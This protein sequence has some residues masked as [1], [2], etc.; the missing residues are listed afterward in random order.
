LPPADLPAILDGIEPLRDDEDKP[1]ERRNEWDVGSFFDKVLLRVWTGGHAFEV[2]RALQWL[3]TRSSFSHSYSGSRGA[4]LH[5][6]VKATP[7]RVRALAAHFVE[8]LVLDSDRWL[9]FNRFRDLVFHEASTDMLLEVALEAMGRTPE[10]VERELFLYELAFALSYNASRAFGA[11]AF[12][13]LYAMAD[14]QPGFAAI[15][16]KSVATVLPHKH[17][18]WKIKRAE[19][20]GGQSPE[21][22][23]ANFA[24]EI[25]RIRSG[26]HTGWLNW[27]SH[28]YFGLFEDCD[29]ALEPRER[30]I[31]L[32]GTE[33]ADAALAGFEAMLSRTDVPTF[34]EAVT[35]IAERNV[36]AWWH[37]LVAG[38]NERWAR[39]AN[40]DGLPEDLLRALI[41]FDLA[42]PIPIER[43]SSTEWMV[44]PWKE[45]AL[46]T[47]ADLVRDAY[48]AVARA[49]FLRSE[50][51]AEGLRELLTEPQF[52]PWRKDTVISL[53]R[54]FPNA[55][56]FRLGDLLVGAV[57]TP[58]THQEFLALAK[59]VIAGISPVGERQ[60]DMWL[61]AAYVVSPGTY[62]AKVE[63][64][65]QA[66][67]GLVFDLRDAMGYGASSEKPA[68]PPLPQLEFFARLTGTLCPNAPH[69]SSSWSGDTNP[70]DGADH[71]R[72]LIH[73]ISAVPTEA[74]TKALSRLEADPALASYKPD[75]LNV[76]ANQR[77][78]RRD[79]EYD[80]PDWQQ[81]VAA[82]AN[83]QPA[84]VSDLHALLAA[85]LR[86][87]N[88]HIQRDNTDIYKMFWNVGGDG[89][90]TSPKPEEAGRDVLVTLLRPSLSQ[91]GIT[92]E[93]EGHMLA[94]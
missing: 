17:L 40:L 34:D 12:D 4:P 26:E 66:R 65:A 2:D 20:D 62:E 56:H 18:E 35:K 79:A 29:H 54:E 86:D 16:D 93:P 69:P 92:A 19:D 43:G 38:I 11:P 33:N 46:S 58:E 45:H 31:A 59:D 70:W 94:D 44:Q 67:P 76:L 64:R 50:Q 15:R 27:A 8:T 89:K 49:R 83:G 47:R 53:L 39:A 72:H 36:P 37:T 77:Q 14:N 90:T 73:M 3:K 75:L 28:V 21:I 78:R 41:A 55:E 74:A 48:F 24:K 60:N 88:E 32:L 63:S 82:L 30:L 71:F 81:T 87:L 10:D 9:T 25:V 22:L 91:L 85:H 13:R 52:E 51:Y 6:A 23:C 1:R 42:H 68:N 84:T 57:K 80:R 7:N 61:V 5:D